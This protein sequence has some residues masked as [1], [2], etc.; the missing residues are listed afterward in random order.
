MYP[1][2]KCGI[3]L[4][5]IAKRQRRDLVMSW[6]HLTIACGEILEGTVWLYHI[7]EKIQIMLKVSF[8]QFKKQFTV[9]NILQTGSNSREEL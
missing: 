4:I 8:D 3:H 2:Y 6:L 7:P 9:S 5:Q 1:T